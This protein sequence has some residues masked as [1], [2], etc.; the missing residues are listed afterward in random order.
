M[1]QEDMIA[2]IQ[3]NIARANSDTIEEIYW[4]L[5]DEVQ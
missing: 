1:C 5:M 4:A 2:Y 3:E